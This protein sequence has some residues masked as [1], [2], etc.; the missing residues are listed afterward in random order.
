[1]V[2]DIKPKTAL[3]NPY[4]RLFRLVLQDPASWHA[5]LCSITVAWSK[6]HGAKTTSEESY[7]KMNAVRHISE[8]IRGNKRPS[9]SAIVAVILLWSHE[10]EIPHLPLPAPSLSRSPH[11]SPFN[12]SH[13]HYSRSPRRYTPI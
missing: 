12:A 1:M 9:E 11:F 7:H 3:F 8:H 13:S 5:I 2:L 6:A 4:K 10:V